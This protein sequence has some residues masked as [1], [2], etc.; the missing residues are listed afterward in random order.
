MFQR[1]VNDPLADTYPLPDILCHRPAK[2]FL[3]LH[4]DF[5]IVN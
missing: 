4:N 3:V 1:P 5:G 2:T